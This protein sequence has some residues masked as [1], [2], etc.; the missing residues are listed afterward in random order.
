MN[1]CTHLCSMENIFLPTSTLNNLGG[2]TMKS[3]AALLFPIII[4]SASSTFAHPNHGDD[5]NA[6]KVSP[7]A[8]E[9]EYGRSGDAG[10]VKRSIDIDLSQERIAPGEI[11]IKRGETI[12]LIVKNTGAATAAVSLGTAAQIKER[13]ALAKKFPTME[14]NQPEHVTIKSGQS[15]ELIWEFSKAG[16]FQ[17]G[18]SN[19]ADLNAGRLSKVIVGAE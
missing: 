15:A 5:K 7:P 10:K 12:K 1:I 9:K 13:A 16:E 14:M 18:S 19:P 11:R 4:L 17:L 8:A 2:S 6:R 3:I